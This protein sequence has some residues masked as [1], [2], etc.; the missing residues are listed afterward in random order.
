MV[1]SFPSC[2][3]ISS[4]LHIQ[5]RVEHQMVNKRKIENTGKTTQEDTAELINGLSEIN[6]SPGNTVQRFSRAGPR[7]RAR[8]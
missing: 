3:V 8:E 2:D 7:G 4:K 6:V 1:G 5:S